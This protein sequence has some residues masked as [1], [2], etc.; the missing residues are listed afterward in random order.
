MRCFADTHDPRARNSVSRCLLQEG[1]LCHHGEGDSSQDRGGGKC[2]AV[3]GDLRVHISN[4]S[5][6][7]L[8]KYTQLQEYSQAN[9]QNYDPALLA[10]AAQ[11]HY[12]PDL[13]QRTRIPPPQMTLYPMVSHPKPGKNENPVG[14]TLHPTTTTPSTTTTTNT[15][16]MTTVTSAAI[17]PH[18][19]AVTSGAIHPKAPSSPTVMMQESARVKPGPSS[20]VKPDSEVRR[21]Y[22]CPTFKTVARTLLVASLLV[23]ITALVQNPLG[24]LSCSA[25]GSRGCVPA[26]H[27]GC[28]ASASEGGEGTT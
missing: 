3:Y 18:V 16:A 17:P 19:A 23:L 21:D 12:K 6:R 25:T 27:W 11:M 2:S 5:L 8:L 26:H 4:S 7:F 13:A 14:P 28:P 1:R 15:P 9:F 24:K 10:A 20:S 22:E